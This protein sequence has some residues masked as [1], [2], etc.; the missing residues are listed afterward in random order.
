[1]S[2]RPS[3]YVLCSNPRSGTT[4][5]C[6]LLAQT[7]VAGCP[8]SFFR[9]QSLADWCDDWGIS[10]R[11]DPESDLFLSEYLAAMVREG[12]GAT[13]VFGLRLMG[14]N[15][16]LANDWLDRVHP[17]Q[18]SAQTRFDAAFGPVRFV[19][20]S[21]KDKLAEAVSLIR[22]EQTG[23]WHRRPDGA[24]LEELPPTRRAG[25]D[26]ELITRQIARLTQLDQDWFTWFAAEGI[27]P[28]KLTYEA[29]AEDPQ[30][31]LDEVLAF[32]GRDPTDVRP[33]TPGVKKLADATTGEWIAAYRAR[34]PDP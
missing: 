16:A 29:L 4:L 11:I 32:I 14:E 28:L 22:A 9:P 19:H 33:V 6:D 12:R 30:E 10:T 5:L 27:E 7:G 17:G 13:G 26:E 1:M 25:Y 31:I 21:R 15:L 23:L 20:L 18:P 34:F 24:P 8:D 3:S 2:E